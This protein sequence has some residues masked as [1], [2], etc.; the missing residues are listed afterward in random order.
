[1]LSVIKLSVAFFIVFITI[2]LKITTLSIMKTL[3]TINSFIMLGVML[4]NNK[5][6]TLSIKAK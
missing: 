3:H 4:P 5:N 2:I 6:M 1:M